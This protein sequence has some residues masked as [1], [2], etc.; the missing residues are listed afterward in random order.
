MPTASLQKVALFIRKETVDP[1]LTYVQR[2]GDFEVVS[3]GER[4]TTDMPDKFT[5]IEARIADLQFAIRL[6]ATEAP[7]PASFRQK[8]LGERVEATEADAIA[9]AERDFSPFVSRCTDVEEELNQI[10]AERAK[11]LELHAALSAWKELDIPLDF[12]RSTAA[13]EI[14]LGSIEINDL[15]DFLLETET[16]PLIDIQIVT[17]AEKTA[18]LLII[19]HRSIADEVQRHFEVYRFTEAVFDD[20]DLPAAEALKNLDYRMRELDRRESSAKA[21]LREMASELPQLKLAHDA[22]KW[23]LEK[24]QAIDHST[25]TQKTYCLTGWVPTKQLPA[26]K[27]GLAEITDQHELV[28]IEPDADEAAPV[29]FVNSRFASPFQTVTEFFGHPRKAEVDPTPFMAPFFVIFFGFC[30]TDAGY[31]LLLTLTFLLALK[32]VPATKEVRSVLI[33][34]LMCGIST[35][36]WG[37]IFGGYFGLTFEQMPFLVNPETGMFYGQ[38]FNPVDD[39]VPK[40]MLIA[41][42]FGLLQLLLGVSLALATHLRAGDPFKAYLVSFPTIL[43]VLFTVFWALGIAGTSIE[44]Q[45]PSL[46][47]FFGFFA[48]SNDFF[49]YGVLALLI[50]LVFT[51]GSGNIF[52]RPI[53]GLLILANEII[54]WASNLLSYSRLFALGLATGIIAMSFNQVAATM[55][56]ML[57]TLVAFPV[58]IFIILLGH[59]LNV[60]LNFIGALVHTARLQFVEFFGRFFEGGGKRF[61]PLSRKCLYLFQPVR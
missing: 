25:M 34:L 44:F 46:S 59:S 41:Y 61:T 45:N 21:Q 40:I 58:M 1:V 47:S 33:L 39:L 43:A 36:I 42:G 18:Y 28:E 13:T 3:T 5:D 15:T 17:R 55:G 14:R 16:S 52:I 49:G 4:N 56:E 24:K 23:E 51:M 30:L 26:L 29:K 50:L 19:F 9:A 27:S 6:I 48:A 10:S 12:A 35:I 57:P 2:F 31:G 20:I 11:S 8:L 53:L 32:I 54:G 60:A 7:A 38:I 22:L 37:I